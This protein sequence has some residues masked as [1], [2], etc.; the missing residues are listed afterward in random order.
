MNIRSNSIANK[1]GTGAVTLSYG[2]SIPPGQLLSVQGN[3]N[4]SGIATVGFLTSQNANITGVVT[5]TTF[6]GNG[7]GLTNIPVVSASKSIALR[8]IIADPP[9]RS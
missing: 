9:L 8:Y 3:L 6:S 5:A 1:T 2:A 7:S 4:I